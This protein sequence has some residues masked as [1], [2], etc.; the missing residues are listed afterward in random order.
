[1]SI[2]MTLGYSA[3]GV[4]TAVSQSVTKTGTG[5]LDIRE[6]IA[7]ETTDGEVAYVVDVSQLVAVFILSDQALTIETN[8]GAAPQ[9]TISLAAGVPLM[10]H[11]GLA[12]AGCPFS[13]D[14]TA[15]FVTNASGAIANLSIMT[16]VDVTV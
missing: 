8:D 2:T 15:L 13:D 9:E 7:D 5:S 1:M 12:D 4:G 14:I 11:D 6:A 16:L 10:W 3:A